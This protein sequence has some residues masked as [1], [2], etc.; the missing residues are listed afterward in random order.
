MDELKSEI[1]YNKSGNQGITKLKRLESKIFYKDGKEEGL[2]S[3]ITRCKY[4]A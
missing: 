1:F 3:H 4:Q 2:S